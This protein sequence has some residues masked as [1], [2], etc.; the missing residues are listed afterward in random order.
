[1]NDEKRFQRTLTLMSRIRDAYDDA[2]PEEIFD[3]TKMICALM[4]AKGGMTKEHFLTALAHSFATAAHMN[5]KIQNTNR[6]ETAKL[7][8]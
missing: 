2:P 5:E 4:A 8:K 6:N 7:P 3:A 1:M